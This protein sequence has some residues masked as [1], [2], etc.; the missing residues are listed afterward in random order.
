MQLKERILE[1]AATFFSQSGLNFTMQEIAASL[2]ISKKTIYT[3]YQS[4]EE[5]LIDMIDCMFSKIHS[6]KA[7]L[8]K[9]PLPIEDRIKNVIIALPE[10]YAGM[11]LRRLYELEEKYPMA[12]KR[13]HEHLENNWEP[14]IALIDEGV[15]E[16]KI[17]PV[18]ME[19]L[20]QMITASIEKFLCDGENINR[21]KENL[22]G[23]MDIIMNGIKE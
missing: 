13:V 9:A 16:G 22:E 23:M 5:L 1:S 17:K 18:P 2:N 8:A 14:T 6:K 12:A 20:K 10:E 7:E 15:K 11:E 4:K 3:V 21:Y 19:I